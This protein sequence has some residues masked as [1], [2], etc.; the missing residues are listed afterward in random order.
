MTEKTFDFPKGQGNSIHVVI[1]VPS[2]RDIDKKISE[3]EFHRRI[4]ETVNFLR[5]T[6]RG[7]TKLM[8]IGNYKSDDLNKSVTERVAK[9][10]AYTTKEDY[11]KYDQ[12]IERWLKKKKKQW[13]QE[14]IAYTYNGTMFFI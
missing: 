2:T 7:S 5:S 3:N 1:T 9:V 12:K 8:G 14:S 13:G 6:L 4:K 10:E 11:N